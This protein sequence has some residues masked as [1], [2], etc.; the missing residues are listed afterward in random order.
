MNEK[1]GLL[2][3]LIDFAANVYKISNSQYVVFYMFLEHIFLMVMAL[4]CKHKHVYI[5]FQEN[6]ED[7][8]SLDCKK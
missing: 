2:I 4:F 6:S 8:V 3:F 5:L 1:V 7:N